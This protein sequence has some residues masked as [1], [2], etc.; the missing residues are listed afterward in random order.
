MV[1]PPGGGSKSK[2]AIDLLELPA[3]TRESLGL[4]GLTLSTDLL[5][6]VSRDF[7]EEMRERAD[8]AACACLLLVDPDPL[9]LAHADEAKAQAAVERAGRV[10]Q[11]A[12]LLGCNAAAISV[13]GSDNEDTFGR[14]VDRLRLAMSKAEALQ[15]NLLIAPTTGLTAQPD[16]VAELLKKTGGFRLGT[17]PDFGAAAADE[18]PTSYLR[19]LTP[20]ASVVRASTVSFSSAD[21]KAAGSNF[22]EPV[23]HA[24]YDLGPLVEAIQSVGYE[25]TLSIDF[26]GKGDATLGVLRSKMVLDAILDP[27]GAGK[28]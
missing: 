16:R 17:Y 15:L 9:A 18:D 10:L 11:A 4:H 14:A 7:L 2:N 3:F 23:V 28:A 19:R 26:R 21:G 6:G 22:D 25:G 24:D 20:Y 8:K 27:E 1:K 13:D 5:A 12:Q